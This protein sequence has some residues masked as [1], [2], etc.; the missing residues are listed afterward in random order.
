MNGKIILAGH[1]PNFLPWLGYFYKIAKC[2]IFVFLDNLQYSKNSFINRNKIKTSQGAQWLT[3]PV[4]TSGKFGQQILELTL[5]N[6]EKSIKKIFRTLELNY[7]K[8]KYFYDYFGKFQAILISNIDNLAEINILLIQWIIKL[9]EIRVA[10]KRSSELNNIKGT[11]TERLISI[12]NSV[13]AN[14]YFS[15]FGGVKYQEN[16]IFSKA[17]IKLK[18]TD[19]EHPIYS[20]LYGEFIPNLSIIDLLFNCGKD[21]KAILLSGK[22]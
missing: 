14:E 8:T 9:L 21:S 22:N 11:S 13:G 1:Q 19:F 6:K 16:E 10:I 20:Q 12:C 18:I 17:R 3:L 15:G 4:V 2:D 5:F 7:H